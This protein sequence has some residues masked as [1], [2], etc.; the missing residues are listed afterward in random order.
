M[1][2]HNSVV[3]V[4]EQLLYL[5][6]LLRSVLRYACGGIN[7]LRCVH[8]ATKRKVFVLFATVP[9]TARQKGYDFNSFFYLN[10]W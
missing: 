1:I 8:R 2:N 5:N 10:S 7:S 6:N 3:I 4:N 9:E